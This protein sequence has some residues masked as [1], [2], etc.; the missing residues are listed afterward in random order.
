MFSLIS[1]QP[2]IKKNHVERKWMDV[3]LGSPHPNGCVQLDH[4]THIPKN[5]HT[6]LIL[7]PK[8]TYTQLPASS[9]F[10]CLQPARRKKDSNLELFNDSHNLY[11]RAETSTQA[12]TFQAK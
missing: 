9:F 1:H 2:P 3:K 10:T 7:I 8:N 5:N 11:V 4:L 6:H 12:L